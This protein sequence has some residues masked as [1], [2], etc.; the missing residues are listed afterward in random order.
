MLSPAT[1]QAVSAA[2]AFVSVSASLALL[3]AAQVPFPPHLE[4]RALPQWLVFAA[5][6]HAANRLAFAVAYRIAPELLR[7]APRAGPGAA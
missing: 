2:I 6:V 1:K 5:V 4:L 7:E 3:Y